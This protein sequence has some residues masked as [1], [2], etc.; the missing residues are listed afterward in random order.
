MG[1]V[2]RYVDADN[3]CFFALDAGRGFRRLGKKVAGVF[4]DLDVP[5][6]DLGLG[7]T[8]GTTYRLKV[9]ARGPAL[10]AFVDGELWLSGRD[11]ELNGAGRFGVYSWGSAGVAFDDLRAFA[12]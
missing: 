2:F 9:V 8:P 5:A 11:T 1:L 12:L 7:F 4:R 6:V 10:R 3:F